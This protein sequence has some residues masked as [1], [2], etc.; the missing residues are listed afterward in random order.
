MYYQG[1]FLYMTIQHVYDHELFV[2]Y[3]EGLTQEVIQYVRQPKN[4]PSSQT[5]RI[6]LSYLTET[7]R[8]T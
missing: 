4:L 6:I 3:V 5:F 8:R 1:Y 2:I 7:R